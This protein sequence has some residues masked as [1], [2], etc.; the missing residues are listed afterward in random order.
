MVYF[1]KWEKFYCDEVNVPFQD[2]LQD[3]FSIL[4]D[5]FERG[6]VNVIKIGPL[7]QKD[8]GNCNIY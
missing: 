3:N 4:R 8:K 6:S 1:S 7:F 2:I 5:H